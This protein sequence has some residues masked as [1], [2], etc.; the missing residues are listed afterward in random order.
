MENGIKGKVEYWIHQI[1]VLLTC[2]L[3]KFC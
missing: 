1:S 3:F 2:K